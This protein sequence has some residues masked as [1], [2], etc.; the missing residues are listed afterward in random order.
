MSSNP[1]L[2]R[3]GCRRSAATAVAKPPSDAIVFDTIRRFK[4]LERPVVV[5]VELRANDAKVERLLDVGRSRATR[6]LIVIGQDDR[7]PGG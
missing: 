4:G 7:S 2:P 6:H 5:L 1:P 3:S